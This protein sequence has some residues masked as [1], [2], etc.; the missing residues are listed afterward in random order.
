MPTPLKNLPSALTAEKPATQ[1]RAL[2]PLAVLSAILGVLSF[3]SIFTES[4]SNRLLITLIPLGGVVAGYLALIRIERAPTEL[5]GRRLAQAGMATAVVLWLAGIIIGGIL[6]SSV[7]PA[8]Y[9]PIDYTTL[10]PEGSGVGR[11][12]PPSVRIME[13]KKVF[14]RG[15]MQARRQLNNIKEF[16]LMPTSGECPSCPSPVQ[17]QLV[18]VILPD[19]MTT[20]YVTHQIGVAGRFHI[21]ENDPS[22]VIYQIKAEERIR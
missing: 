9:Q 8:G 18:R 21:S 7:I 2:C 20:S 10:W 13:D 14:L 17:G 4:W 19:D 11:P 1:Y 5:L 6:Y 16:I 3:L 12:I 15:F 22:G